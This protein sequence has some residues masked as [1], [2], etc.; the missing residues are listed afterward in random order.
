MVVSLIS[1][2]PDDAAVALAAR[3]ADRDREIVC[4]LHEHRVLTVWQLRE[5]FFDSVERARK[6]LAVLHQLG[7]V[8]RFRPHRERGSHPCHYVL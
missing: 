6:R 7:V 8:D 2:S 4:A 3:L 5:L 1:P